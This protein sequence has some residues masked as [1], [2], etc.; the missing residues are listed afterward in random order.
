MTEPFLPPEAVQREFQHRRRAIQSLAVI[1][2]L[3]AT[4]IVSLLF[5]DVLNT[6]VAVPALLVGFSY[7]VWVNMRLWR[8]PACGAHLGKLYLGLNG[9]KHCPNCGVRLVNGD[10]DDT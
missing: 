10:P 8:C 4:A 6:R 2:A 7:A 9:P 3:T 1:A 5:L